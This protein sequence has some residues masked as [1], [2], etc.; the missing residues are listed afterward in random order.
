MAAAPARAL[1]SVTIL[2]RSSAALV[3]AY[4][5]LARLGCAPVQEPAVGR[6]RASAALR[7]GPTLLHLV[8]Q[9]ELHVLWSRRQRVKLVAA[10]LHAP[11]RAGA[12][13]DGAGVASVDA[14]ADD[15]VD[16]ATLDALADAALAQLCT[17]GSL[18]RGKGFFGSIGLTVGQQPASDAA[19][20]LHAHA[21][22]AAAASAGP[23]GDAAAP[24]HRPRASPQASA[25]SSGIADDRLASSSSS[26]SSAVTLK[27]VVVGSQRAAFD[28]GLA[29]LRDAGADQSA[30]HSVFTFPDAPPGT[31]AVRLLPS[32]YSCLV[33][34]APA[35]LERLRQAVLADTMAGGAPASLLWTMA[36]PPADEPPP[37]WGPDALV[38]SAPSH[39]AQRWEAS[40]HGVRTGDGHSGQL[41]VRGGPLAGLDVRFCASPAHMPYFNEPP[42]TMDDDVGACRGGGR[43]CQEK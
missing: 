15:A 28:A 13:A 38:P 3:D 42:E 9:P 25:S 36:P 32:Q 37:F 11:L 27:E 40:L 21:P 17:L 18:W 35:P 26:S 22:S 24:S 30:F 41:L 8:T 10:N 2:A 16:A 31:P 6:S 20:V 39:A 29:A 7:A 33:F 12:A 43:D 4:G 19:V 23:A 1:A 5:A 34:T 14:A